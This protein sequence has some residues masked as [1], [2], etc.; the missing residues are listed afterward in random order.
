MRKRYSLGF[1]MV[2]LITIIILLGILAA[3]AIPRMDGA[4]SFRSVEFRDKAIAAL[5]Y[6]QKTA[7][8][9]RR[10]VCVTLTQTT[11][12][13]DID[14][15][16]TKDS[17]CDVGL[18]LPG[19]SASSFTTTHNG[20]SSSPSPAVLYFQPNGNMT[21]DAA[22]ATIADF[23]NA[24]DGNNVVVRGATGYVGDGT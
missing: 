20:F 4:T 13:L 1:T 8:S 23:D 11:V 18:T 6:A 10:L 22:G 15:S 19:G 21:S 14:N 24:V 17:S 12:T 9:H 16:A 3:V 5:R 2:E 7:A